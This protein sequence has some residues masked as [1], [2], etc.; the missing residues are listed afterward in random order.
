MHSL[1]LKFNDLRQRVELFISSREIFERELKP[2][3][4]TIGECS[5]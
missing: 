3:V 4:A 5:I 1:P 2:N